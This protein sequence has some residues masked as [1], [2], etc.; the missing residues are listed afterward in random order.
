MWRGENPLS[1]FKPHAIAQDMECRRRFRLYHGSDVGRG[2]RLYLLLCLPSEVFG[3]LPGCT[4][5][6]K[7]SVKPETRSCLPGKLCAQLKGFWK[8]SWGSLRIV[9][10]W[11]TFRSFCLHSVPHSCQL[12]MSDVL[13]A[14]QVPC[15]QGRLLNSASLL[16]SSFVTHMV[17][18]L[19]P[20]TNSALRGMLSKRYSV[21]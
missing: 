17:L 1:Y 7:L 15:G 13:S 18:C 6:P 19:L 21:N 3:T 8:H 4:Y 14:A 20:E 2:H 16:F 11:Q 5:F 10:C 9:W 12:V